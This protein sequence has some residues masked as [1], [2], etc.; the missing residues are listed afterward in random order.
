[1][2]EKKKTQVYFDKEKI[3]RHLCR[4][5]KKKVENT[6]FIDPFASA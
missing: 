4:K 2:I 6:K 5:R 3:A 1:M